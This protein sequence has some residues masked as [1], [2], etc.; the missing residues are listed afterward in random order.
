MKSLGIEIIVFVCIKMNV[1]L[2][3]NPGIVFFNNEKCIMN[4]FHFA[5]SV[6]VT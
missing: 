3:Y 4:S 6:F 5:K 1:T 2:K